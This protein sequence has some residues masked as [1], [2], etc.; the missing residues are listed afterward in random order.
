[1]AQYLLWLYGKVL[2]WMEDGDGME[3]LENQ[4]LLNVRAGRIM[5]THNMSIWQ[6]Y[7]IVNGQAGPV[8]Q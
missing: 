5:Q 2:N 4:P 3:D 1:M 8:H 6:Q 7:V